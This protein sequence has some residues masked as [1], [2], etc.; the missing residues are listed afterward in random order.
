MTLAIRHPSHIRGHSRC[1][2]DE[3]GPA[4]F[5]CGGDC[6]RLERPLQTARV[7]RAARVAGRC[8]RAPAS[9]QSEAPSSWLLGLLLRVLARASVR[10]AEWRTRDRGRRCSQ[11]G[12][13]IRAGVAPGAVRLESSRYGPGCDFACAVSDPE[14]SPRPHRE[15]RKRSFARVLRYETWIDRGTTSSTAVQR[16]R[17]HVI[18]GGAARRS[19]GQ[20]AVG[21]SFGTLRTCVGAEPL[22]SWPRRSTTRR[23]FGGISCDGETRT[24]TGDTTIFRESQRGG[25]GHE[26][27]ANHHGANGLI[28]G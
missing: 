13:R 19:Y 3:R 4:R 7:G 5:R 20:W 12:M 22:I 14:P 24:R 27:P 28:P 25:V 21:T 6:E 15:V 18:C 9:W 16:S 26:R 10:A 2:A 23:R 8:R 11:G 17:R 1:P